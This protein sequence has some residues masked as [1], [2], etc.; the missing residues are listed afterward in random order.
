MGIWVGRYAIAHGEVMEHGPWL[1]ERRRTQHEQPV[2]LL[3]LAEPLDERSAEFCHEVADAI[4][5]LFRRE[6]LSVTGGL[7]R[8][9]RQAHANLAEWNR[10]SLR[11]HRVAVAVTCVVISDREVTIAQV[12]PCVALVRSGTVL[13]RLSPSGPAVR[14]L[15]GS[16]AIE[17]AFE[18]IVLPRDELLLI[19]ANVEA[20][21]GYD[22][23]AAALA[24]GPERALAELFLQTR[25][26]RDMTAVLVADLPQVDDTDL[27]LPDDDDDEVEP[28]LE[29]VPAA[30]V[31]S[32]PPPR[33]LAPAGPP[34]RVRTAGTGG[35]APPSRGQQLRI[36]A[37]TLVAIMLAVAAWYTLPGLIK[38]D[39]SGRFDE[40]TAAIGANLD[41]VLKTADPGAARTAL[42]EAQAQL[43]AARAAAPA[44]D[45]RLP[46]LERRVAD[47]AAALD[48]VSEVTDVRRAADAKNIATLPLQSVSLVGAETLWLVDHSRGRV[49]AVDVA[50]GASREVYRSGER[51][52]GAVARD[53]VVAAW[54][55]QGRRLLVIDSERTLWSVAGTSAPVRLPLRGAAELRSVTA[56]AVYGG[57]IYLLDGRGG[58]VWRYL[59]AGAGFDSERT[60]L[61][62]G[63]AFTDAR[64]LV[65]DGDVFVLDG[66]T[67]RHFRQGTA[68]DSL[69]RG[70]DRAPQSPVSLVEDVGRGRFY[71]LEPSARRVVVGDRGGTFVGQLRSQAF[72]DAKA[73]ALSP[74]GATLYVL[75]ADALLAIDPLQAR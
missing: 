10:R 62:G 42:A 2:R 5:A 22:V 64:A 56:L 75:T 13:R 27:P 33:P 14:P 65:V 52:D 20:A 54:D 44:G 9:L 16:D 57:N 8:A 69:L 6:A 47:A 21:L 18:R 41:A 51:Y 26:V 34:I 38:S 66:G 67:L 48:R 37:A 35:L 45:A 53:P 74:D 12:G 24:E 73:I 25:E 11:E 50:G 40:I 70:I 15:G 36:G 68:Q 30:R 63:V 28:V 43:A 61:L 55:E 3:V 71:I 46:D 23:V 58:E 1:V 31:E 59:P 72:L 49:A 19:T 39:R 60:G 32:A 7:L 29:P 17:P 4:A